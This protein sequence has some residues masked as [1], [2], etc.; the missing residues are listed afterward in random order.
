MAGQRALTVE[1]FHD[2]HHAAG[3]PGLLGEGHLREVKLAEGRLPLPHRLGPFDIR[4]FPLRFSPAAAASLWASLS[5]CRLCRADCSAC[6]ARIA[7][8]VLTPVPATT[9]RHQTAG[10]Q[11]GLVPPGELAESVSCRRGTRVDRLVGQ[12]ALEVHRQAVGRFVPACAVLFQRLHYNPV[13]VAPH[14]L[15]E[16]LR[17]GVPLRCDGGTRVPQRADPRARLRR[18]FLTNDPADLVKRRLLQALSCRTACCRSAA[19]TRAR[20]AS[21]CRPACR[22]PDRSSRPVPGS[23]RAA[24]RSFRRTA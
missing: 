21:R 13:Q 18:L 8:Q 9:R 12:I 11:P 10:G 22:C 15:A 24:C 6:V 5:A 20:P 2:A 4:D 3:L 14:E 1:K 16:P 7:C 23:C 17:V 19:H